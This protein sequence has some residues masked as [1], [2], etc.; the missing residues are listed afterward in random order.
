MTLEFFANEKNRWGIEHLQVSAENQ[1]KHDLK[2]KIDISALQPW[3]IWCTYEYR[4][5]Y[6][7]SHQYN[8]LCFIFQWRAAF[9]VTQNGP[10]GS[11]LWPL[12][13][14]PVFNSI[15]HGKFRSLDLSRW[16][17]NDIWRERPT[18]WLIRRVSLF[19]KLY[20]NG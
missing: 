15:D 11:I 4:K 3:H 8:S 14:T 13:S 1:Y 2:K 9:F 10:R 16:L 20:I 6:K 17:L 18:H 12:P 19:N 7:N 5:N